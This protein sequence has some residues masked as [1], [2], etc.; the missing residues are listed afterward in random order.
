MRSTS[1]LRF[2]SVLT[3]F[4]IS[5]FWNLP[6][7]SVSYT[8]AQTHMLPI[9]IQFQLVRYRRELKCVKSYLVSSSLIEFP[10]RSPLDNSEFSEFQIHSFKIPFQWRWGHSLTAC[11]TAT[12][13]KSKMVQK[14]PILKVENI[15][16][17]L[18]P[19]GQTSEKNPCIEKAK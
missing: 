2:S 5:K 14:W 6:T 7:K 16:T 8:Y 4:P 17:A 1:F 10:I 11:N 15:L 3:I 18:D 19:I 9:I 12:P 13:S